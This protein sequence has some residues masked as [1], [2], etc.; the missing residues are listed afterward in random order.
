M[1]IIITILVLILLWH[2]A[3]VK[4][5]LIAQKRY[6]EELYEDIYKKLDTVPDHPNIVEMGNQIDAI[7][8]PK[9]KSIRV[10]LIQ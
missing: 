1:E 4:Q 2:T 9:K 7:T 6:N 10:K 5:I 3:K 8:A